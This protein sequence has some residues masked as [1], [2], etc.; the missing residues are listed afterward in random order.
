VPHDGINTSLAIPVD[1]A[2]PALPRGRIEGRALRVLV[3]GGSGFIG[4]NVCEHL[5]QAGLPC[6]NLD[7]VPPR[8]P[9]QAALWHRVDLCDATVL[10]HAVADFAPDAILHLGAR[11][12]LNGVSV[13]DYAA[14]TRGVENLIDAALASP[15]VQ[16]VVFASSRLV[17]KIGHE[18]AGDADYCPTTAY[19]ESKVVGERTVRARAADAPW[20]W[21]QVRPTSIWGPWFGVPY[22]LFFDA[23]A[24]GRYVHPRGLDIMKSFGFVGNSVQQLMALLAA[25]TGQIDRR[26]L[27]LADYPPVHVHLMAQ[28][29]RDELRL[30]RGREVPLP[31][32][33][34]MAGVGDI[35]RRL[36]WKEPPLT[37]FRLD[38]LVTP[39]VYDLAPLQAIVGPLRYEMPDGVR[40]T[41]AWMR[42]HEALV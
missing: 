39:M 23:V 2:G 27:Y 30:G 17:C 32:L 20:S 29:I 14:N 10:R 16:R 5:L 31:V 41:L 26:T 7:I 8:N 11:T 19:G 12:D 4:T 25:P 35:A 40:L 37:R 3:T 28:T 42:E 1:W 34:L 15:G 6:R 18:P 36:G 22:K 38:N 21:V 9:A 13:A 24:R 33:R